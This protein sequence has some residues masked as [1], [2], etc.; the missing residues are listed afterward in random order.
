MRLS[1]FKQM[2]ADLMKREYTIGGKQWHAKSL[3]YCRKKVLEQDYYDVMANDIVVLGTL[4]HL[5]VDAITRY[6]G[7]VFKKEVGGYIVKGTPDLMNGD[8][9]IEV[10]FT[11][12]LPKEAREHDIL[13]LKIYLWLL[14][15]DKGYL[16]YLTP[17]GFRE[18][19]VESTLTDEDILD[20]IEKPRIPFWDWE[21]KYCKVVDCVLR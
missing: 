18:F 19:E 9:I 7:N 4:V 3:C 12:Y 15:M 14:D 16:W 13:Q 20:L 6:E 8:D 11:A 1:E 21:C 2:V 17:F 5:G 10:K